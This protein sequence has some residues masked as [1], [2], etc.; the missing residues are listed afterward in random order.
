[1]ASAFEKEK[2][3]GEPLSTVTHVHYVFSMY[4]FESLA[5]LNVSRPTVLESFPKVFQFSFSPLRLFVYVYIKKEE[6][7]K[8]S[9]K[10]S[11]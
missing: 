9:C 1:M 3:I 6:E 5:I 8:K 7:E 11:E 2:K 10:L 4:T